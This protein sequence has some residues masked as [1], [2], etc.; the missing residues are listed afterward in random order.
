MV[1]VLKI[2]FFTRIWWYIL[3]Y[4]TQC[5]WWGLQ[6]PFRRTNDKGNT[7]PGLWKLV[8]GSKPIYNCVFNGYP[9]YLLSD[10]NSPVM[11]VAFCT[12]QENNR[13]NMPSMFQESALSAR[14]AST[15][16]PTLYQ[17]EWL[18][19]WAKQSVV[20]KGDTYRPSFM[21]TTSSIKSRSKFGNIPASV[22]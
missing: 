19:W 22:L 5:W 7:G 3:F 14:Q 15:A 12:Y 13:S 2:N 6:Q 11:L 17:E 21:V 10:H 9:W 4:L 16:R 20:E 8:R 1:T 18:V